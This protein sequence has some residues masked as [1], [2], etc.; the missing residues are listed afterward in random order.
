ML[1]KRRRYKTFI[2]T[3]L[4]NITFND[5]PTINN[6][7]FRQYIDQVMS[8]YDENPAM[9]DQR[10]TVDNFQTKTVTLTKNDYN[11]VKSSNINRHRYDGFHDDNELPDITIELPNVYEYVVEPYMRNNELIECKFTNVSESINYLSACGYYTMDD[12]STLYPIPHLYTKN[13]YIK[14]E[15]VYNIVKLIDEGFS[16]EEHANATTHQAIG[17]LANATF[18]NLCPVCVNE[19]DMESVDTHMDAVTWSI[20]EVNN[21]IQWF[22]AED[23]QWL[24]HPDR[25]VDHSYRLVGSKRHHCCD[26]YTD[27]S[28][29]EYKFVG[30]GLC[31][32]TSKRVNNGYKTSFDVLLMMNIDYDELV[33]DVNGF[34]RIKDVKQMC[35]T[36]SGHPYTRVIH[37]LVVMHTTFRYVDFVERSIWEERMLKRSSLLTIVEIFELD[38]FKDGVFNKP[39]TNRV[40]FLIKKSPS[41]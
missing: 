7:L 22:D 17:E 26:A 4:K 20:N 24:T 13:R 41:L 31:S 19:D 11:F 5:D 23:E 9:F 39:L 3:A 14:D 6:Q 34:T 16:S 27:N 36:I 28:V 2:E 15:K 35:S 37:R 38:V 30:D 1:L 8:K 40:K 33:T 21:I 25:V 12:A 18:M 29:E 10:L 32:G